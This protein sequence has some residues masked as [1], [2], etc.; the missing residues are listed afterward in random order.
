MVIAK[1]REKRR[2]FLR[3]DCSIPSEVVELAGRRNLVERA[4]V[5]DF[6]SEGLKLSVNFIDL[7]PGSSTELI[8][9]L[10]EKQLITSLTGEIIWSK[11]IKNKLEVGLKIKEMEKQKKK[12]ILD[13]IFPKL[14]DKERR[15]R[16]G[17]I[18]I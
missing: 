17:I 13:W 7:H 10:P 8:L 11:Y 4:T 14:L 5:L 9:F 12:D 2:K 1:M 16:E 15:K 18:I 3:F 6:S